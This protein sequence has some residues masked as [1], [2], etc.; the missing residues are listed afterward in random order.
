M[1]YWTKFQGCQVLKIF[2]RETFFLLRHGLRDAKEIFLH[3]C[4]SGQATDYDVVT[5]AHGAKCFF[6]IMALF[7][8]NE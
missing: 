5:R 1:G 4:A 2:R 6:S 8:P 7:S 3:T